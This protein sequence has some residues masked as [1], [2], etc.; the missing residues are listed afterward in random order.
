MAVTYYNADIVT[1]NHLR[2]VVGRH[3]ARNVQ[4]TSTRFVY[5]FTKLK[6]NRASLATACV[7]MRE[8]VEKLKESSHHAFELNCTGL[9]WTGV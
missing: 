2:F 1:E 4:L 5:T 3:T 9:D 6:D 8:L 7:M